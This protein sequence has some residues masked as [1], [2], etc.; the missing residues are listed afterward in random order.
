M[1][2]LHFS[3]GGAGDEE[4]LAVRA[5]LPLLR[6][7]DEDTGLQPAARVLP[8]PHPGLHGR[9]LR[10]QHRVHRPVSVH[11]RQLH[12]TASEIGECC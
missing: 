12:A 8:L 3:H 4:G 2:L 7:G 5:T 9:G 11:A 6:E 10:R 1:P